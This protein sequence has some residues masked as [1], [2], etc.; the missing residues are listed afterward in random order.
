MS[1][2][3]F[4]AAPLRTVVFFDG[5]NVLRSANDVFGWKK[6]KWDY[7]PHVLAELAKT[8]VERRL[9]VRIQLSD[10]RFYT[11]V[12]THLRDKLGRNYWERLFSRF[13]NDK[14]TVVWRELKYN[15]AGLA[16]EK[17]IDLRIGLDVVRA[18]ADDRCDI[19]ILFSQDTDLREAIDEAKFMLAREKMLT[20]QGRFVHFFC[21]FPRSVEGKS[22]HGVPGMTWIGL[23]PEEFYKS[24]YA[25]PPKVDLEQIVRELEEKLRKRRIDPYDLEGGG[26]SL[27]GSLLGCHSSD[28]GSI[29]IVEQMTDILVLHVDPEC[30]EMYKEHIGSRVRVVWKTGPKSR[31]TVDVFPVSGRE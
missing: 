3:A 17:G 19:V 21:V 25:V 28:G 27:V 23:Y 30:V 6:K 9:D 10:I 16:R 18:V 1:N 5:Q 11:G 7:D 4:T 31:L 2:P 13:R 14:I 24:E 15:E 20:G 12:P 26:K 22:H 29:M 8:D